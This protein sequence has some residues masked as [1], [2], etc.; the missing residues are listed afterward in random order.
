LQLE[1]V[2]KEKAKEKEFERKTT[3]QKSEKSNLETINSVKE[4]AKVANV[5]HDTIG[6]R[7]K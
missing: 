4:I 7:K 6:R 1:D 3:F 5:S 2:F